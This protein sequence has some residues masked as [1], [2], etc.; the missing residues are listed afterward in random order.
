MI[1]YMKEKHQKLLIY[2]WAPM[3]RNPKIQRHTNLHAVVVNNCQ[4]AKEKS[5]GVHSSSGCQ[6]L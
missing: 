4:D 5:C 2:T 6:P 1:P 3:D